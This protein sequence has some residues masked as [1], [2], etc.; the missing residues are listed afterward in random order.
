MKITKEYKEL[1]KKWLK[2]VK[3]DFLTKHIDLSFE[4]RL[5]QRWIILDTD[6]KVIVGQQDIHISD[7]ITMLKKDI[8]NIESRLTLVDDMLKEFD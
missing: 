3:D 1:Q 6:K 2:R 4:L 8:N 5:Q 7:Y